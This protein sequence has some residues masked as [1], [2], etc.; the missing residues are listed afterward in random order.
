MSAWASRVE[1]QAG[2]SDG[3]G[4]RPL[5][6][7]AS[8]LSPRSK[9]RAEERA[10]LI[11]SMEQAVQSL[12]SEGQ[13]YSEASVESVIRC[14]HHCLCHGMRSSR[15]V[16]L[17]S[18]IVHSSEAASLWNAAVSAS[19]FVSPKAL[20]S[21]VRLV[22]G[23]MST[24]SD[25]AD[26][27]AAWVV[28]AVS[29]EETSLNIG[30]VLLPE[31]SAAFYHS[32]SFARS[33]V[34]SRE[35]VRCLRKLDGI[36]FR[37]AIGRLRKG[38]GAPLPESSARASSG[39]GGGGTVTPI[40]SI[41]SK[42]KVW[43]SDA[44]RSRARKARRSLSAGSAVANAVSAIEAAGGD[45]TSAEYS[46]DNFDGTGNVPLLSSELQFLLRD[47]RHCPR[48]ARMEPRIGVPL[49][50]EEA[51]N[52]LR[53]L[54]HVPQA[55][56]ED[57]AFEVLRLVGEKRVPLARAAEHVA[58]SA[59]SADNL[60]GSHIATTTGAAGRS[61]ERRP[62]SP[63]KV[64]SLVFGA[65][66][67]F[68]AQLPVAV[69]PAPNAESLPFCGRSHKRAQDWLKGLPWAHLP[70]LLCL[71]EFLRGIS[72]SDV[73]AY[74]SSTVCGA[75][76][77][78][79]SSASAEHVAR[80]VRD[81]KDIFSEARKSMRCVADGLAAKLQR[82]SLALRE[83]YEPFNQDDPSHVRLL[84]RLWFTTVLRGGGGGGAGGGG[85]R[86]EE[87]GRPCPEFA[88]ISPEWKMWAG[89]EDV[90][91]MKDLCHGGGSVL[92]LRG[93][94][95]MSE[96]H[97]P[98]LTA[99]LRRRRVNRVKYATVKTAM[100]ISSIVCSLVG[101]CD[102]PAALSSEVARPPPPAGARTVLF[103]APIPQQIT[104]ERAPESWM[105]HSEATLARMSSSAAALAARPSWNLLS[106]PR[107]LQ[108]LFCLT[109]MTFDRLWCC[110]GDSE[111]EPGG[112]LADDDLLRR[113]RLHVNTLLK[114]QR[115]DT[116]E[117]L[118]TAWSDWDEAMRSMHQE[119][120]ERFPMMDGALSAGSLLAQSTLQAATAPAIRDDART[121]FEK[122]VMRRGEDGPYV[123]AR[124]L[125]TPLLD[126]SY[127]LRYGDVERLLPSIP[128][129]FRG[130][131][132]RRL[133]R[134]LDQGK[135]V[136]N[137]VRSVAG[138]S[139]TLCV[140][141]DQDGARFGFL[142]TMPWYDGLDVGVAE[143]PAKPKPGSYYGTGDSFVFRL[144]PEFGLY[145]WTGKNRLFQLS[146]KGDC[147]A[148]GG[149]ENFALHLDRHLCAGVSGPCE[150][151]GSPSLCSG[152]RKEFVVIDMEAWGFCH[153]ATA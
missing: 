145:R 3:N 10:L 78:G 144:A 48:T 98:S 17:P 117:D 44:A 2:G 81:E 150:T 31:I 133:Y 62:S 50:V 148:V 8:P 68:L 23:E 112:R 30:T 4:T 60:A 6:P 114:S 83:H 27:G 59:D 147:L 106:R 105:P 57:D 20:L 89:F 116:I 25:G 134:L 92:A 56:L 138:N 131:K 127:L 64:K 118:W 111:E 123:C 46:M 55:V 103:D 51:I 94:V 86:L 100:R 11:A 38:R 66:V 121:A 16:Q 79:K 12:L 132:W 130:Y 99:I 41:G 80:L 28:A 72:K 53:G 122:S 15:K 19:N 85:R 7:P 90:N 40:R 26:R 84:W 126:D 67:C 75:L 82:L 119:A 34:K 61:G 153:A 21:P 29:S 22:L 136:G 63:S 115:I 152:S 140:V 120:L 125:G 97:G 88:L 65:L 137:F 14:L 91:A 108:E 95:Y 5:A 47:P 110:Y 102:A 139:A 18:T 135:G 33:P 96:V 93:Y 141:R 36:S 69:I 39:G 49:I 58:T 35:L 42:G 151:F 109:L 101:L 43:S 70:L 45:P 113:T 143:M 24:G 54:S 52:E 13:P 107:A 77:P 73:R 129:E 76:V 128:A 87:A 71:V 149:G 32:W 142:A 9:N 104:A 124:Q 37:N 1:K 74:V 146:G